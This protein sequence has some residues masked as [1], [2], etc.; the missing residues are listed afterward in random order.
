MVEWSQEMTCFTWRCQWGCFGF[1][2]EGEQEARESF[3]AHKCSM[4]C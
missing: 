3:L 2:F 1:D 4:G